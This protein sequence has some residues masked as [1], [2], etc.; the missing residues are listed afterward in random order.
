[1]PQGYSVQISMDS[2]H[3]SKR[4][5]LSKAVHFFSDTQYTGSIQTLTDSHHKKL[6]SLK[7]CS[8]HSQQLFACLRGWGYDI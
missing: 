5:Y 4:K 2:A 3:L 6:D 8:L 7:N 1:M